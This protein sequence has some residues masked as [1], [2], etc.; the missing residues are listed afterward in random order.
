[1]VKEIGKII[2]IPNEFTVIASY[3]NKIELDIGDKVNVY[4]TAAEI[5]DPETEQILGTYDLVKET[6]EIVE[7][8]EEYFICQKTS[9]NLD[10]DF[11]LSP[12]L[13]DAG[14]EKKAQILNVDAD[15]NL[16]LHTC[17]KTIKIGDLVKLADY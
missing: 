3:K 9:G 15:Q 14:L 13:S 6:L 4:I 5:I 12:L 16:N 11:L 7:L 10:F 17:D 2:M 1:M 8:Y